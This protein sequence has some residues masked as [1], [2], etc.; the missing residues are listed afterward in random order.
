MHVEKVDI[1][2]RLL[3]GFVALPIWPRVKRIGEIQISVRTNPE[4]IRPVE[5]FAA[6][7]AQQ[8]GDFLVGRNGPEFVLLVGAGD[9]VA[10]LVEIGAVAAAGGLQPI[11]E[12]AVDAPFDDAVVRLVREVDVAVAIDGRAFGELITIAKNF[13]FR[14][15]D[16]RVVRSANRTNSQGQQCQGFHARR[17]FELED[18]ANQISLIDVKPLV[19]MLLSACVLFGAE[20]R[21]P[22]GFQVRS[23]TK[24]NALRFPMFATVADDGRLFVTESSGGDLYAELQNQTR[25]CRISVLRDT[26]NDGVY[27]SI[28]V[29]AENLVPSMGIVW[30]ESK[31]YVADPPDLIT[32]ED[33]D[34]DERADKR[35]VILTG[36]GHR[37]NGSL[38][39]LTFG[40]D[41]WLYMTTGQPDGYKL[42]RGDGTFVEGKSGALI[43]CRAD[44]SD[45]E[46]LCRGFEN[47]V[48]VVFMPDGEIVGTDNWFRLPEEGVRDALVHLV[49]GGVYPLDAHTKTESNLF[50]SGELLPA[51]ELYPAVAFSGLMRHTGK[52]F[53][54]KSPNDLL[55]AQFN[56]RKV[57]WHD[58]YK[59]GSTFGTADAD[60]VTTDDPDFHP[61]DVLEDRDG[62]VLVV[63]TGSWYVHHCPTGRIRKTAAFGGIYRVKYAGPPVATLAAKSE[64]LADLILAR[65]RFVYHLHSNADRGTLLK[66]LSDSD[67]E[68]RRAA[69]IVLDQAPHNALPF[70]AAFAALKDKDVAL[71]R[72]ALDSF[73]KHRDWMPRAV[74]YAKENLTTELAELFID[75]PEIRRA[76]RGV[77]EDANRP[78]AERIALLDIAAKRA[79]NEWKPTAEK[80]LAANNER[81]IA[82]ALR[83]RLG[84]NALSAVAANAS[85]SDAIRLEALRQMPV[86]AREAHADFILARVAAPNNAA[87]RLAAAGLLTAEQREQFKDDPLISPRR[88]PVDEKTLV[89]LEPLLQGGDENRGQQVF[90]GRAG[91]SACHRVGKTGGV[92]GPDLTRVGA[93]RSGRDLIESLA[94]PSSTFAQGYEPLRVEL[95]SGEI[96]NGMRARQ[97]D[98]AFVL[99]DASGAETR[100]RSDK[101]KRV[102]SSEVSIMPDGLLNGLTREE[103]RDLLAYLQKLK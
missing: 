83:V 36:F 69:L 49:P 87:T 91:C 57:V 21:V 29:F 99:H 79:D 90:L 19:I 100:L 51:I 85:L 30:R 89:D 15:I 24:T 33:T 7:V 53:P 27:D 71:R 88:A 56:T 84:E 41:G 70:E 74:N 6:K 16:Q 8:D 82:A 14:A 95:S 37:D 11:F 43:R 3:S 98:D 50:F 22:E 2:A 4:V 42:K 78:T 54:R 55:S 80:L 25:G 10:L 101:I 68:R 58:L 12:F 61:S 96:L 18:G 72:A 97:L 46:V 81:L 66:M 94:M 60:F 63:D 77:I 48:E 17:L 5:K 34:G 52:S 9:Q 39:G 40:P 20:L 76:M 102:E 64:K 45:V 67:P 44:G 93:I 32:L 59:R 47:L 65:H 23:A 1:L 38:H 103:I 62:S 26:D 86:K 75:E 73:R 28:K 13:G 31:L 92:I 35:T